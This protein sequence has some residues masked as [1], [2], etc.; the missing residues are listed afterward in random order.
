MRDDGIT[1]WFH[2][3]IFNLFENELHGETDNG[4]MKIRYNVHVCAWF[5]ILFSHIHSQEKS[6]TN[7]KKQIWKE[8]INK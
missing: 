2:K 3:L 5:L 8:R 7:W 1:D 4:S 6:K